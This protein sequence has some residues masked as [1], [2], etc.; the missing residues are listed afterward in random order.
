MNEVFL[1]GN[2]GGDIEISNNN[3]VQ[4]GKFSVAT[5]KNY[6]DRQDEWQKKTTWHKITLFNPTSH[7]RANLK[8]GVK[9]L[10]KGQI[11]NSTYDKDGVTMYSSEIIATSVDILDN[12]EAPVAEIATN[13]SE[14]S[15][16][17][18]NG[19]DDLPF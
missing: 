19:N 16:N 13:D 1:L 2:L 11:N 9:V 12:N 8:K 10:V 6:K 3:N 15:N 5:T 18:S 4:V 14:V 7:K 17:T